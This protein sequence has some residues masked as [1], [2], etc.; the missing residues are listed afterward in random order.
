MRFFPGLIGALSVFLTGLTVKELGGKKVAIILASLAYICS[1]AYLHTDYLFQPVCFEH[2]FWLLSGYLILRMIHRQDPVVWIWLGIVFGLGFLNKYSILFFYTA[3]GIS[4]LISPYRTLFRSRYFLMA[5][6]IGF[7]LILPNLIWQYMNNWP[8]ISHMSEL[9]DSQ[10]AHVNPLDFLLEQLMMNAQAIFLW[11]VAIVILL[12]RKEEKPYRLFAFTYFFV[13]LLILLGR[14]KSYYTLGVY[15]ILFAFGAYFTE[16]YMRKYLFWVTGFLVAWTCIGLYVSLSFD[17]IPLVSAEQALKKEGYRWEDG[18][19]YDLPQDM[20]DMTGWK[21]LGEEVSRIYLDLPPGERT[22][23][24]IY[25]YHYG[26]AGA[27][28]FYGKKNHIPQPICFNGSFT[29]WS[30]DSLTKEYM[31]W[32]HFDSL[33]S[34]DVDSLLTH[35][36]G[37]VSLKRTIDNPYFRENGTKIYLCGFPTDTFRDYYKQRARARKARYGQ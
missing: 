7:L 5:L 10:L 28:M 37:E 15:P 19:Y 22:N 11:L 21:E 1:P 30:P 18:K 34:F 24:D 26:Q 4:L 16:K 3:F 32:V 20:A 35:S 14:G 33:N 6:A 12:F 25:C 36:F 29:F 2:F 9:H 8:V 17:G 27:I 13:I 31:I 23:C